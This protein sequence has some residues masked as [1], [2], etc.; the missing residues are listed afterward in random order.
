VPTTLTG[1]VVAESSTTDAV[2]GMV[3]HVEGI[4]ECRAASEIVTGIHSVT[5][6]AEG[7]ATVNFQDL[8]L[9]LNRAVSNVIEFSADL[10]AADA[11][12]VRAESWIL[13]EL[14]PKGLGAGVIALTL[15]AAVAN[16]ADVFIL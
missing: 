8:A 6:A 5:L 13:E 14:P 4:L 16:T 3:Y 11:T 9:T 7:G 15:E 2:A 10:S 1:T 12:S